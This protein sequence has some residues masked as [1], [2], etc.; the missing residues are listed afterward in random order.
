[1]RLRSYWPE[2]RPTKVDWRRRLS[3]QV[4]PQQY[5]ARIRRKRFGWDSRVRG[6]LGTAELLPDPFDGVARP[7]TDLRHRRLDHL[8]RPVRDVLSDFHS[9]LG[10]G[11]HGRSDLS[12]GL[13]H[14]FDR[15][16]QHLNGLVER[17]LEFSCRGIQ[18]RP[19]VL[20]RLVHGPFGLADE[21]VE[22]AARGAARRT[23]LGLCGQQGST[24]RAVHSHHR[25]ILRNSSL[26]SVSVRHGR[27]W[28]ATCTSA[29]QWTIPGAY[30]FTI[31]V[32][33]ARTFIQ[34]LRAAA[35]TRRVSA[36]GY[37]SFGHSSW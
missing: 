4:R 14:G 12:R 15:G 27:F 23:V 26:F 19:T 35:V 6:C 17:R 36:S 7:L 37:C 29:A 11:L 5:K 33:I 18:R 21:V 28:G 30:D 13:A 10:G 32:R 3:S 1:M 20:K 25:R 9:L 34:W 24:F 16:P 8:N 2:P 31:R 22:F